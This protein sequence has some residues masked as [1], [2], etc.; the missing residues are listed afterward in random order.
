M[1]FLMLYRV[2]PLEGFMNLEMIQL[3]QYINNRNIDVLKIDHLKK[4]LL[5]EDV[6]DY[7]SPNNL[8]RKIGILLKRFRVLDTVLIKELAEA[9]I[10]TTEFITF[11]SILK[12]ERLLF[13][14]LNEIIFDNFIKLKKYISKEEIENFML[15][16][17]R[18]VEEVNSWSDSSKNRMKNKLIEFSIRAGYLKKNK[19]DFTILLPSVS[20]KTREHIENIESNQLVSM[21]F[22]EKGN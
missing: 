19:G 4:T 21:L 5:E 15:E 13:D 17:A 12:N 22:L 20:R 16:K 7:S 18:Q 6:L 10:S 9:D 1:V 8:Q 11:Y 3:A 2:I 14:F